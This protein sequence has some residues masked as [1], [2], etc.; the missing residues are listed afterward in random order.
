MKSDNKFYS[1]AVVLA[2]LFWNPLSYLLIYRNTPIY[3]SKANHLFYWIVFIGGLLV[4]VVIQKTKPHDRLKKLALSIAFLGITF[5]ALVVIDRIISLNPILLGL[6]EGL[7]YKPNTSATYTTTEFDYTANINSLGLR[8]RE[9]ERAKGNKFRILC[10]GDS[11]TFGWGVNI[12]N[13]WPRK[14]EQYLHSRGYANVEV[15]NCG[16][17]GQHTSAYKKLMAEAVPLLKPDLVLVGVL[18]LD[19][20]AQLYE[21]NSDQ[22]DIKSGPAIYSGIRHAVAGYLRCSL[23]HIISM[24]RNGTSQS[25]TWKTQ[26]LS[27]IGNFNHLRRIRFYTLDKTVQSLFMSGNLN[28]ALLNY[29]IDFPDR[30]IIFNNPHHPAT[31]LAVRK[32]NEDFKDMKNICNTH[33][34][35]LVFINLPTSLF[36]GH[37]VIRTPSDVLNSYFKTHNNIDAVYH[38]VA[39]HNDLPY[40]ELTDHFI[41]LRDKSSFFFRYDGHPNERGYAEMAEFIGKQLIEQQRLAKQN[42]TPVIN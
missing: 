4:I 37:A 8:D 29:Y 21:N 1:A 3:P 11:W 32:M 24:L 25:A 16:K 39:A 23:N 19:D 9:I 5:S 33:N 18:Q 41:H 42:T 15:I 13:S 12:E 30:C 34:S 38:S 28:P 40:I 27:M 10:F 6:H 17:P 35:T 2:L 31:K 26:S 20:L 22:F 7:I 36:T 14:L